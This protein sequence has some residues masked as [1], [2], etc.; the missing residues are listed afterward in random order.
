MLYTRLT[1]DLALLPSPVSDGQ[2]AEGE[3]R[4]YGEA[5]IDKRKRAAAAELDEVLDALVQAIPPERH[6]ELRAVLRESLARTSLRL[7]TPRPPAARDEV[8]PDSDTESP[9]DQSPPAPASLTTRERAA[10]IADDIIR[11]AA[12]R[13]TKPPTTSPLTLRIG[14]GTAAGGEG[15]KSGP[16]GGGRHQDAS[17]ASPRGSNRPA[18]DS[19]PPTRAIG[20][21]VRLSDVTPEALR[22]L[23][24]GRIPAGKITVLDGDPGLGKSTLLCELAA[25]I[26][27]GDPLPGDNSEPTAPRGVLLFSAEDDVHNT[28]R[29]RIDAAGGDPERIVVFVA[30]PDG[31]D[32]GRPFALPRDLPILDALVERVD[33]ALV[34]FD[35]LVAFLPAGVSAS[36][37]QH[38]RHAL[39]KLKAS[40]ERTGAAIVLVRHLNKSA[41]AN[42]LYRGLGSVGIIGAARSALLLAAD[43]EDPQRRILALAKGNLSRPP[44]SLAFRLEE[45]PAAQVAR[46]VWDSESP[47]TA[48]ELLD[49]HVQKMADGNDTLSAIAA[50]R[51]WLREA[52]A[53]GPRPASELRD[54]AADR[55]I[56]Q[57][58]LYAAR[59][60]ESITM[61][62]E[63]R[64]H[65]RWFWALETAPD[66]REAEGD[67]LP[68]P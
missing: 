23:W 8:A 29:P 48:T 49:A 33:A 42:P 1:T 66:E 38:V 41:S 68:S 11:A 44:A 17:A 40:A 6:G 51:A 3:D 10:R 9:P 37:D 28:I 15:R 5:M 62:K 63:R 56:G 60:A 46:V 57:N 7:A 34:I 20:H 52:L 14:P 54:E 58:A 16:G 32:T 53:A 24:T 65:G 27:R 43:P 4:Q 39:G 21:T 19:R 26:S 36:I 13:A 61:A 22:W 47:W 2:R 31:T 30:V 45:I 12:G 50:A 55:G 35:P 64:V 67:G 18:P 59:K 25:R